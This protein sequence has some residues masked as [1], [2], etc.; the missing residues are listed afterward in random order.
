MR[1]DKIS[2]VA[3]SDLLICAFGS[4]YMKNHREMHFVNV[5][6]RKMRELAK[7]LIEIRK[8]D[9]SVKD[10][11][12]ALNPK[13]YDLIVS[14]TKVVGKYDSE[15]D[16]FDSPTFAMNISTS[17]KQCCN[18]AF[19]L[20]LKKQGPYMEVNTAEIEA[21]L[22]TLIHLIDSNWKYDVSSQAASDL[23][24]KKWNKV[25]IIPLANDLKI[26]KK[27]LNKHAEEAAN[28]IKEG[29]YH[30]G[31]YIQLLETIYCRVLLLNR[32]RPGELQRITLHDYLENDL[33]TSEKYEEFDRTLSASERVL[34]KTFK[35]VVVRGKRGREVPVLFSKEVQGDIK[36]LLTIR[37][38]FVSTTNKLLFGNPG[39]ENSIYGYKVLE[40]Y[41]R[42]SGAKNPKAISSTRLRK[43]LA[44]LSQIFSMSE[45]DLEQLATFMGH[46]NEVHKKSYRLPD[47]VYQTAK[48]SKLLILMEDG[49][50]DAYRGKGL[51]GIDLDLNEELQEEEKIV[52]DDIL[53]FDLPTPQ[54]SV[55]NSCV[56]PGIW[57]ENKI[58]EP[59]HQVM[60][61][62]D[63]R[64]E[65][66]K[67]RNLVPWSMEQ[68]KVVTKFFKSH[69][70]NKKPPRKLECENLKGQYPELLQNKDWLKIKVFIQNIYSKK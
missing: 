68:K 33:N 69:I 34:V 11:L 52:N 13:Y 51:D 48:I 46:T 45:N 67:K 59:N 42:L 12:G 70:Q 38:K 2:F 55:E 66:G 28:K 65:K 21:G 5:I 27:F 16:R 18:I 36:L 32:R 41:S 19:M 39:F 22:K 4:Q 60:T 25:T 7:L 6:S 58:S 49:K 9:Q 24:K 17:I 26:L 35:R 14:A 30:L 63:K 53:D 56:Q 31:V 29:S 57:I 62:T 50:A 64:I 43:H 20:A 37:D 10:L 40:R 1:P 23:N 61:I 44:T 3:K 54:L 15:K 47:D 8:K